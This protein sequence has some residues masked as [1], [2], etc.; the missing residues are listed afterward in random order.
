MNLSN[1]NLAQLLGSSWIRGSSNLALR[2]S[3]AGNTEAAL[4]KTS[5]NYEIYHL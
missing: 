4:L 2:G 5:R 1:I 3:M